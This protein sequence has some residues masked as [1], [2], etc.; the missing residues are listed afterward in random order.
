MAMTVVT[1]IGATLA[2][3]HRFRSP[4]RIWARAVLRRVE[5]S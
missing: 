3:F 4:N 5:Q 2:R 1:G